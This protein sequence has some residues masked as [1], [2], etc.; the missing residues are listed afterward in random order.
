[1]VALLAII[2]RPIPVQQRKFFVEILLSVHLL[3]VYQR[4][5]RSALF[6]RAMLW[7]LL[8]TVL[9]DIIARPLVLVLSLLGVMLVFIALQTRALLR[10][11]YA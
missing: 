6:A 4:L 8:M 9:Q 11:F 2:A 7:A 10:K 3:V 1:M 5:V